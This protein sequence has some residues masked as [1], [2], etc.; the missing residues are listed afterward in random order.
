[1]INVLFLDYL[2]ILDAN[3]NFVPESICALKDIVK[4]FGKIRIV[5]INTKDEIENFKYDSNLCLLAQA[6]NLK[7]SLF[8][9]SIEIEEHDKVVEAI[10]NWMSN[11]E[12]VSFAIVSQHNVNIGK[13]YPNNSI[14][15]DDSSFSRKNAKSVIWIMSNFKNKI[16]KNENVWFTSDTHFGHR[17]IIQY[18]NRPWN[19]GK[20]ENGELVVTNENV[21]AMDNEMIRRWNSVVGKNDTVWHLGDFALGGKEV[22]ERVFPQLNGKINLVMGNHDHWNINFYYDLGFH[23]VYD[24]KIIIHD[25]VILSH[26]PLMFLNS[27]CPFYNVYGHIHNSDAYQ[28]WTKNSCCVCVERHGYMPISWKMIMQKY[29]ELNGNGE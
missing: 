20:N 17:R 1:M 24:K 23:R 2:T 15:C 9:D 14:F 8:F 18:C 12:I 3:V 19:H 6:L 25:F 28:T 29:D 10:S 26:A 4:A 5:C 11:R 16:P 7:K 22:A 27:N 13:A 21:L